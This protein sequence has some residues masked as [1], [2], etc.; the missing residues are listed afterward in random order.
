M[1]SSLGL[2]KE[3]ICPQPAVELDTGVPAFIGICNSRN[4]QGEEIPVNQ[5][6]KLLWSEFG[7]FFTK[8]LSNSYLAYAVRG[9]FQNGGRLCYVIRLKN[10]TLQAL[11]EG[12]AALEF[13][14]TI[15]LVC[16]PDIM[17]LPPVKT[18]PEQVGIMQSAVLK[19]C[20]DL[21]DRFA[22][23]DS[24][25]RANLQ[26][27]QEQR[28]NLT[29]S[30]GALYYPWVR[31]SNGPQQNADFIPPCGHVAGVYARCDDLI[32]I[33]KVPA[34]EILEGVL[35]LEF[36]LNN[37]EQG[38]LDPIGVNFLRVFPGRGIRIWGAKTLSSEQQWLY[39]NVRRLFLTL[40]RWLEREM[41][42]TVFEPNNSILWASIRRELTFYF[43]RLFAKGALKGNS[44]SEAFYIKCDEETNPPEIRD[45]GKVV[46]EIGLAPAVPS[47]FIVVRILQDPSGVA[48]GDSTRTILLPSTKL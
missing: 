5:P 45:T 16:A 14:D 32:G 36:N 48:I 7:E 47:E 17:G 4:L 1:Y 44:P 33:H 18:D 42:D 9:F 12:L 25:P 38:E 21:G 10:A 35:E 20:S 30:Y 2:Y 24:L 6:Q 41:A 46:A 13:L 11:E 15:D 26:K 39:I 19:H 43:N 3:Y 8:P 22:I 28:R 29:G 37:D 34:N 27:V 31:I 23:L 40:G